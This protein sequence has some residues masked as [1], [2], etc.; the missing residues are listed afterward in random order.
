MTEYW[1]DRQAVGGV[2]DGKAV[3]MI[4]INFKR[5]AIIVLIV[6][7]AA[8]VFILFNKY[9]SANEVIATVNDQKITKDYYE[10]RFAALPEREK[11]F[12][13][14]DAEGFLENLITLEIL[15][16]AAESSSITPKVTNA[17]DEEQRKMAAIQA[18]LTDVLSRVSVPENDV[19]GFYD[20]HVAEM[21]EKTYSEVKSEINDYLLQE[22]QRE[23]IDNYIKDLRQKAKVTKN[24]KWLD[25]NTEK[26]NNP[27]YGVLANGKPTVLDLGAGTC[28]PCKMMKPIF[29]ELKQQYQDRANIVLLEIAENQDLVRKYRIRVIPTQIFFDRDGKEYWRHE[30]FLAKEEIEA[31]LRLLGTK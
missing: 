3:T 26:S 9:R 10:R 12:F 18:L 25:K 14:N 8:V 2:K 29:A 15:Y 5:S 13:M 30:G 20:T 16:Q 17:A 24:Q 31:K 22:K 28:V 1:A 11:K 27:F 21:K 6:L 23:T 19:R 7:A 4:R